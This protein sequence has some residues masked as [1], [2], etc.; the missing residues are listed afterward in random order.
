MGKIRKTTFYPGVWGGSREETELQLH[1]KD[2]TSSLLPSVGEDGGS[3][4]DYS[5][6]RK[7][8]LSEA[9]SCNG[10]DMALEPSSWLPTQTS[11]SDLDLASSLRLVLFWAAG[12]I[13]PSPW[14]SEAKMS[15]HRQLSG[16][17]QWLLSSTRPRTWG[18]AGEWG[19]PPCWRCSRRAGWGSAIPR[20]HSSVTNSMP[21][22]CHS[23][24]TD[25]L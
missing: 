10:E 16:Q 18:A 24:G 8:V 7:S 6:H 17:G 13:A 14:L 2:L 15:V 4:R 12:T 3:N 23:A 22:A 11:P 20:T 5:S 9:V 1:E 19:K 21:G 25:R